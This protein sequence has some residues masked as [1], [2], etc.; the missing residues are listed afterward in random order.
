MS[1]LGRPLHL[2]FLYKTLTDHLVDRRF[3]EGRADGVA[4]PIPLAEVRNELA[5]VA[6]TYPEVQIDASDATVTICTGEIFQGMCSLSRLGGIY[7][8]MW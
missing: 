5:V 6:F 1:P 4:L 8:M 3:H 7:P 2:L